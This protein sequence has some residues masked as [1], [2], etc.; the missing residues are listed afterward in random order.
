M[1]VCVSSRLPFRERARCSLRKRQTQRQKLVPFARLPVTTTLPTPPP[2]S[3]T[4]DVKAGR[5]E[6]GGQA[7]FATV[8]RLQLFGRKFQRL[9]ERH[10]SRPL[11]AE[12]RAQ[13]AARREGGGWRVAQAAGSRGLAGDRGEEPPAGTG[14]G[15]GT[16]KES[17]LGS[18]RPIQARLV[19]LS[20]VIPL[21]PRGPAGWGHAPPTGA[22]TLVREAGPAHPP[23]RRLGFE[24]RAER[25]LAVSSFPSFRV[26][27]QP[28]V[29][30][31]AR[32]VSEASKPKSPS[33]AGPFLPSPAPAGPQPRLAPVT[34]AERP[35]G[36]PRTPGP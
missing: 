11:S 15:E 19:L 10:A 2:A 12:P 18:P 5:E 22:G 27:L 3:A 31:R 34:L 20:L 8:S 1:C 6:A 35:G 7:L 21:V 23:R 30:D 9:S 25:T 26:L 32:L 17:P 33:S 36:S 13:A 16:P 24:V 29:T 14:R 4:R 28:S